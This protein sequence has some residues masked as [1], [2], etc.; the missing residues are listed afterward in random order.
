MSHEVP[1]PPKMPECR[2]VGGRGRMV[3]PRPLSPGTITV[4]GPNDPKLK[5]GLRGARPTRIIVDDPILDYLREK[6]PK[7]GIVKRFF[8][9]LAK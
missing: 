7:V 8:N 1:P 3:F 6:E 4:C 5:N 2:Y 9:Y